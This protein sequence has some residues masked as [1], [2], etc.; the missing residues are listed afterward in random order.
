VSTKLKGLLEAGLYQGQTIEEA[1]F[2]MRDGL[3]IRSA[4]GVQLDLLGRVYREQRQGREDEAYRQAIAVRAASVVNGTPDEI[5]T[6]LKLAFGFTSAIYT[7]EYPAAF[8]IEPPADLTVSQ[9][10]RFSP[11][12]VAAF[13]AEYM[14]TI[15]GEYVTTIEGEKMMTPRTTQSSTLNDSLETIYDIYNDTLGSGETLT[16]TLEF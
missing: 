10:E 8:W 13:P 9:L 14:A 11:S 4:Q 2:E 16:D 1:L 12:G 15:E 3:W 6:F 7:P 5:V